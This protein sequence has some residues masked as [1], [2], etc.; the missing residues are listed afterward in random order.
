[1]RFWRPTRESRV[2][3]FGIQDRWRDG[4]AEPI[5]SFRELSNCS[6]VAR[7]QPSETASGILRGLGAR[8]ELP[9]ATALTRLV[10]PGLCSPPFCTGATLK[11]H[12]P[13]IP[14]VLPAGLGPRLNDATDLGANHTSHGRRSTMSN[15]ESVTCWSNQP[16]DNRATFSN[17]FLCTTV[18]VRD[19]NFSILG[20]TARRTGCQ[21]SH[22]W[23]QLFGPARRRA[24]P[25]AG[26]NGDDSSAPG[27]IWVLGAAFGQPTSC[28]T[29]RCDGGDK[30]IRRSGE[31]TLGAWWRKVEEL[32]IPAFGVLGQCDDGIGVRASRRPASGV[33]GRSKQSGW[34]KG[35]SVVRCRCCARSDNSHGLLAVAQGGVGAFGTSS[36]GPG[37]VGQS[38]NGVG[39]EGTSRLWLGRS[40]RKTP[41]ARS[42]RS[43]DLSVVRFTPTS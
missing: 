39:V 43:A 8:R 31:G 34:G 24:R 12:R 2:F 4:E 15:G 20:P 10:T 30:H 16:P 7:C 41:L 29:N 19:A 26:V 3:L 11:Y 23:R 22:S 13:S 17:G 36:D 25:V 5:A 28:S 32:L 1:V 40:A 38:A 21:F 9:P 18:G 37:V 6:V 14:Q 42:S 35:S 33:I 27:K